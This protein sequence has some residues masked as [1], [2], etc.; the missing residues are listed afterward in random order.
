MRKNLYPVLITLFFELCLLLVSCETTTADRSYAYSGE[1]IVQQK[2][3]TQKM[4]EE[5]YQLQKKAAKTTPIFTIFTDEDTDDKYAYVRFSE[6]IYLV[7]E[8]NYR[9]LNYVDYKVYWGKAFFDIVD[10]NSE[11]IVFEGEVSLTYDLV[12]VTGHHPHYL[13]GAA[14][15]GHSFV[16]EEYDSYEDL[17]TMVFIFTQP[18][19]IE[20][21]VDGKQVKCTFLIPSYNQT[22]YYNTAESIITDYKYRKDNPTSGLYPSKYYVEP[23]KLEDPAINTPWVS[24]GELTLPYASEASSQTVISTLWPVIG[25]RNGFGDLII[26][27]NTSI[28]STIQNL[29]KYGN[30]FNGYFE[31]KKYGISFG[32]LPNDSS[33]AFGK[34]PRQY[35]ILIEDY[36]TE[37][38]I[39]EDYLFMTGGGSFSLTG[40][41]AQKIVDALAKKASIVISIQDV[42]DSRY[43]FRFKLSGFG[44]YGNAKTIL[45][46]RPTEGDV[47]FIKGNQNNESENTEID[48]LNNTTT[49]VQPNNTSTSSEYHY[50]FFSDGR[51]PKENVIIYVYQYGLTE[52]N[53]TRFLMSQDTKNVLTS[54]LSDYGIDCRF[55]DSI[56]D[57]PTIQ[58]ASGSSFSIAPH[59]V[60]TNAHVVENGNLDSYYIFADNKYYPASIVGIDKGKDIALLYIESYSFPFSFGIKEDNYYSVA[61]E[62][63][64]IGYPITSI[65]GTEPRVTTGIINARTGIN[66]DENEFQI[67]AQIQ[68]G[69][70]GGPVLQKD[71]YSKVIGITTATISDSYTLENMGFV[72]QDVNFAIK[73]SILFTLQGFN[74]AYNT[75]KKYPSTIDE[76]IKGTAIVYST[77]EKQ[78]DKALIA[79][80]SVSD[81]FEESGNTTVAL[82]LYDAVT[83]AI[84]SLTTS[85]H[86]VDKNT[87][88]QMTISDYLSDLSAQ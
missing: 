73:S 42:V 74:E 9:E 29:N 54:R 82:Y 69:N 2:E 35:S 75:K 30:V 55:V 21:V 32:I 77:M 56:E 7:D 40:T 22:N 83:Q 10:T 6:G 72:T 48:L 19:K 70:S 33:L 59:Y 44:F 67:S 53:K 61:S 15:K 71:D 58:S 18:V 45:D 87:A 17:Q 13:K 36:D 4:E 11:L 50:T 84:D 68:P 31:V 51:H 78:H 37:T 25:T 24:R 47:I 5:I 88:I 85:M 3:A 27:D 8:T 38:K 80:F 16:I 86:L 65:I 28:Y 57:V 66:G 1:Q 49:S 79:I 62:I 60:V 52:E 14:T 41:T 63:Y 76:A 23:Y 20:G 81:S 34:Q 12:N 46:M 39:A 43:A 26:D 64:A